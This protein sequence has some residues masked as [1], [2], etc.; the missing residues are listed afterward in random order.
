MLL[1]VLAPMLL[2]GSAV[3]LTGFDIGIPSHRREAERT[4]LALAKAKEVLIHYAVADPNRPGEL[5]CPDF[6]NDGRLMLNVDFRGGRDVPCATRRGWFP[7]RSLGVEELR[8]GT[9]ERLWY[10]V[11]DM[12][13]AG[14][15]RAAQQRCARGAQHGR[16]G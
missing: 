12:H 16:C 3:A 6:D 8:D 13:H 9:G 2:L 15:L 11:A 1:A 14:T 5:P 4:R 10:A 7:F